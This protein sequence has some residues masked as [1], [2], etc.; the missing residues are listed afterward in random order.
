MHYLTDD[1]FRDAIEAQPE[2]FDSHDIV[3]YFYRR[4]QQDY[5]RELGRFVEA[6]MYP[7]TL[8]NAQVSRELSKF[9][10]LIRRNG[11]GSSPTLG[12]EVATCAR[13][14]KIR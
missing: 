2:D 13:W 8:V 3:R 14:S 6:D 11:D 7:F 1:M 5:V 10:D 12:G 4:R 9:E